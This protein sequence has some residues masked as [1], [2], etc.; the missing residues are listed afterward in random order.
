M[1]RNEYTPYVI[2]AYVL[3]WAIVMSLF[4]CTNNLYVGKG[5]SNCPTNDKTYFYKRMGVKA[6]KQY[7]KW[8]NQ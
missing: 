3:F 6:P 2:I 7:M 5:Y 4:G 8:H 1:K